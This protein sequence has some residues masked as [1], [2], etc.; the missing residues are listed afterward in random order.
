ME[1]LMQ[2]RKC[3][4]QACEL[5]KGL[6]INLLTDMP[7]GLR[8]LRQRHGIGFLSFFL[9]E[10]VWPHPPLPARPASSPR[11]SSPAMKRYP[12]RPAPEKTFVVIA[13]ARGKERMEANAPLARELDGSFRESAAVE[14]ARSISQAEPASSYLL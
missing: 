14:S 8:M 13:A 6:P 12:A 11:T 1:C 9:K 5:L 10:L 7:R 4:E 3:R 2:V